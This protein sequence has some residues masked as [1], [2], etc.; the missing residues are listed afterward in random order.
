MS[1]KFV[2][3]LFLILT[4]LFVS[5]NYGDSIRGYVLS[6]TNRVKIL[7]IQ[8]YNSINNSIENLINQKELIERLKEEN[9]ENRELALLSIAY[10]NELNNLISRLRTIEEFNVE[11]ELVK[12]ISYAKFGDFHKF[13]ID[14]KDFNSSKIYGVIQNGYV[15][16]VVIDKNSKPLALL[17]GDDKCSYAVSIG[18]DMAPAIIRGEP[19]KNRLIADFIPAWIDVKVGDEVVTSGLDNIFFRGLK[20]GVVT[21]VEYSQGYKVA[22]VKP[23][24]NIVNP[25][26]LYIVDI[27]D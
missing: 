5:L 13:W 25:S 3:T 10:A 17:N 8:T 12:V 21:K 6:F 19:T 11:L 26:Y 27:G 14:Y 18:E 4:L 2:S 20:V 1:K 7:Y 9:R 24:A 16:G 23:K 22:T 15:A